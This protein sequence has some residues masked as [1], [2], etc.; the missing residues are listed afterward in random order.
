[1]KSNHPKRTRVK[2]TRTI[3]SSGSNYSKVNKIDQS[4]IELPTEPT[5]GLDARFAK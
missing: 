2:A 3:K 1:M 5:G 4:P